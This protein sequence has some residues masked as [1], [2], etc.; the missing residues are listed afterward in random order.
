MRM[1]IYHQRGRLQSRA[2]GA[3]AEHQRTHGNMSRAKDLPARAFLGANH[4]LPVPA[5]RLPVSRLESTWVYR[6]AAALEF[7]DA[8]LMQLPWVYLRALSR[9]KGGKGKGIST[10]THALLW[11]SAAFQ[12]CSLTQ[13]M[14]GT[15]SQTISDYF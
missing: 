3:L 8:M 9:L 14:P 13:I 1:P 11:E 15:R 7:Q 5:P 6:L 4:V 2:P 10:D 12:S